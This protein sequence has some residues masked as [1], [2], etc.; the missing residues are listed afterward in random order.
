MDTPEQSIPANEYDQKYPPEQRGELFADM[1]GLYLPLPDELVKKGK[2]H[3]ENM[4]PPAMLDKTW[5]ELYPARYDKNGNVISTSETLNKQ[6]LKDFLG[7]IKN[8]LDELNL[9][10]KIH[11]LQLELDTYPPEAEERK[12]ILSKLYESI[13]PL[14]EDL[15]NKKGYVPADLGINIQTSN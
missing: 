12:P 13:I 8:T 15:V 5:G 9:T 2:R 3:L 1:V 14:V 4:L 11:D 10:Q 6:S 7:T